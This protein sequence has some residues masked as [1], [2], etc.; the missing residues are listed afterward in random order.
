MD[1]LMAKEEWT[2]RQQILSCSNSPHSYSGRV[3]LP[4]VVKILVKHK[5][6]YWTF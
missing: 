1:Y 6:K 2:E 4:F 3:V 5:E